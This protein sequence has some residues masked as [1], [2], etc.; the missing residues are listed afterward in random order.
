MRKLI[1]SKFELDLSPFK[2]SDTEENNWFSDSFFTKYS[3]PFEI[4]LVDDLDIALGFI[5]EYNSQNVETY[6]DLLYIH[7]NKIEQ[8]IL[9]I[10]SYQQRLSCTLRFGYEQLPSFDKLLSELSL[11]KF[12]LP[13]GTTIYEHAQTIITQTFP[14]VNYNFPQIHVDKYDPTD[15]LWLGFEGIINN[16]VSGDFLINEVIGDETFNRNVMQPLPYW[17]HILQRGMIDGGYILSGKILTDPRLQKAC[18]FG[19]VDYYTAATVQ[20]DIFISQVSEDAAEINYSNWDKAKASK[21]FSNTVLATPGKY[22]ISGTVKALRWSNFPTYFLIKYRNTTIWQ[23]SSSSTN[24]FHGS[25]F[26]DYDVDINFETIVDANVNDITVEA[27]QYFTEEQQIMNLTISAIRLNDALGVSIPTVN[28]ENKVDLTRAV[29][30]ITFLEFIKVV[31][32]WFNYDLTTI[33]N[34]AVMNPI[35][36]AMNYEEALDFSSKEVKFPFRKFSQ[37]TSFLLKFQDIDNKDF[38]FLPVFHSNQ[39]VES[40][41]FVTDEKTTTIEINGLPLPLLTRTTAQTAYALENNDSKVYLVKYDG[42]FNGNNLAQPIN[43][44]EIAAVHKQ[45][46]YKWFDFRIFAQ[47]FR[48][49]FKAWQEEI[50]NLKAKTKIYMYKRFHII[51]SI[52]KTEEKPEL[53]TI[54]IETETLK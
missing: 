41:N 29:P 14:A 12:T 32:N 48:V 46:W 25:E 13:S 30:N 36:D 9:E 23:Q 39:G 3:F 17:I 6:F 38:K 16:R 33:G 53:F 1:H 51:K 44:Y 21:Y 20:E 43:E 4:D 5:S 22:N 50:T 8:A 15:E 54:E 45:Y 7:N 52:N 37:G 49:N 34:Y 10:E 47:G 19:D 26:R 18:L 31:K 42:L 27:Y 24:I 11:D 35:E 2:I 40:S 28:N